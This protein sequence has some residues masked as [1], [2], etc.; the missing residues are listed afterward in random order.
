MDM[1]NKMNQQMTNNTVLLFRRPSWYVAIYNINVEIIRS[2]IAFNTN[3][4][5]IAIRI[6]LDN[7]FF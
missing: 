1:G 2:V 6:G 3:H 5:M 4:S 7:Y